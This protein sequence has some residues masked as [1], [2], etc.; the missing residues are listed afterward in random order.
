MALMVSI[1]I[2]PVSAGVGIVSGAE[3]GVK[4]AGMTCASLA[5]PVPAVCRGA[6]VGLESLADAVMEPSVRT[7]TMAITG[8]NPGETCRRSIMRYM[9]KTISEA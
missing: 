8:K 1:S 3:T 9:L 2:V 7:A 4:A 5:L 6:C